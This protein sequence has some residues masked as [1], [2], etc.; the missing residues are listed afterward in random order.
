[1][2]DLKVL[3]DSHLGASHVCKILHQVHQPTYKLG[4]LP[5]MQTALVQ[6][7]G[8]WG[9]WQQEERYSKGLHNISSW[10]TVPGSLEY[11]LIVRDMCYCCERMEELW[12]EHTVP[13][14]LSKPYND[15]LCGKTCQKTRTLVTF[16][17]LFL[18]PQTPFP[19]IPYYEF[20]IH[21]SINSLFFIPPHVCHSQFLN[22]A[23]PTAMDLLILSPPP[24]VMVDPITT[25]LA[26]A[27][28]TAQDNWL[29]WLI[30][31]WLV[32]GLS[33]QTQTNM[34]C[35]QGSYTTVDKYA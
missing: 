18:P 31:M 27:G 28:Q 17:L 33:Y 7:E 19:P 5:K 13:G 30:W 6:S 10:S 35:V 20:P 24:Y 1:M 32:H 2:L 23:H 12:C 8:A 34:V 3:L 26:M 16:F 15:V 11:P 9:A 4:C 29:P 25:L 21:N 22:V 14:K